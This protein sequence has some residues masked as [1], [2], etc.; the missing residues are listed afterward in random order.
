MNQIIAVPD[1]PAFA[2]LL[3]N[4]ESIAASRGFDVVRLPEADCADALLRN[5][6]ELALVS[7]LGYGQAVGR[8]DY[9]IVP[10]PACIYQGLTYEASIYMRENAAE[11]ESCVSPH[12]RDFIPQLGAMILNDKFGLPFTAVESVKPAPVADLLEQYDVV[13]D[14]GFDAQQKVVLDVSDEWYD[15]ASLSLPVMMWVCRPDDMP[16]DLADMVSSFAAPDL[17]TREIVEQTYHNANAEREGAVIWQWNDDVE[18]ALYKLFEMMFFLQ[19]IPE[20]PAIKLW[21]RDPVE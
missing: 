15:L 8:A 20:I 9:R 18:P 7:P 11:I 12:A 5:R 17:H 16:E 14:W 1:N 4:I 6:A 10:G 21:G 2:P 19:R 13:I 3:A